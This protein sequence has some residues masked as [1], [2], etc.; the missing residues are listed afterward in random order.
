[1][2]HEKRTREQ[3][4]SKRGEELFE[5][6]SD[7]PPGLTQTMAS[8]SELPVLVVGRVP[9]PAPLMLHQS[10]HCWRMFWTPERP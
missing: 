6:P 8:M 3:V 5:V 10:P 9:K 4:L 1:M 2:E 7:S